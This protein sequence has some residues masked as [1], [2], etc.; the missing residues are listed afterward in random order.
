MRPKA[1]IEHSVLG[2]MPYTF[3]KMYSHGEEKNMAAALSHHTMTSTQ[4]STE[5]VMEQYIQFA[6]KESTPNAKTTQDVEKASE[7]EVELINR[8][9]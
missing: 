2:Q 9:R 8:Y 4:S 6:A 7:K 5:R 1:S 3:T